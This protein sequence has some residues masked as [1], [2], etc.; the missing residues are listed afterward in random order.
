MAS[1]IRNSASVDF[2]SVVVAVAVRWCGLSRAVTESQSQ[3]QSRE[4]G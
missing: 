3:S 2:M 4:L 1:H